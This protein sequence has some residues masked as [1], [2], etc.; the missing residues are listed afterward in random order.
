MPRFHRIALCLLALLV[1]MGSSTAPAQ[2]FPGTQAWEDTGDAALAMVEGIHKYLDREL[3]ASVERRQ[4][5]WQRDRTS[6]EAYET[7]IAPNRERFRTIIGAVGERVAPVELSY[8]S[9]PDSPAKVAEND[10]LAIYAVR[11]T[12]YPG[13]DAEGLLLEPKGEITETAWR[14]PTAIRRRSSLQGSRLVTNQ[15]CRQPS[16]SRSPRPGTRVLVPTLIDRSDEFSGGPLVRKTNLPHREWIYRMAFETGPAHHWLRGGQGPR[17]GRLVHAPGEPKRPTAVIG[18]GEGGLIAF[19][20]AA[21][22]TRIDQAWS[23]ATSAPREGVWQEP[24]YRNVWGLLEEFG[25]AEIGSLIAPV[26]LSIIPCPG[27]RGCR[28]AAA[29]RGAEHRGSRTLGHTEPGSRRGS[30]SGERRMLAF[31]ARA[32]A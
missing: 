3:K 13:V 27:P 5:H 2:T 31:V 11:W 16:C 20:A 28:P 4:T 12:V 29:P 25:D 15:G 23:A 9:G 26:A 17:G 14:W 30:S 18:F 7:S 24:I 10:R 32:E 19:Y 6:A 1:P 21:V 8:V 22:D